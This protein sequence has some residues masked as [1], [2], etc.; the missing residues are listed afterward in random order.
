MST[1]VERTEGETPEHT[2]GY[3]TEALAK[4]DFRVRAKAL[5]EM[6]RYIRKAALADEL[7]LACQKAH[8]HVNELRDAWQRGAITECDGWGGTRSN[9]NADVETT[10]RAAIDKL[11][12]ETA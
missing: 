8:E 12:K 6:T 2:A 5:G 1:Y 9:R 4:G 7:V 10:L 11:A 3:I